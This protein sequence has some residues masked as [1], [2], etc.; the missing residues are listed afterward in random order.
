[1]ANKN[2]GRQFPFQF[3]CANDFPFSVSH[4]HLLVYT[5]PHKDNAR[6]QSHPVDQRSLTGGPQWAI[7][8]GPYGTA[9]GSTPGLIVRTESYYLKPDGTL[10]F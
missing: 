3:V 1:M 5:G 9:S 4:F 7:R 8:P 6:D 10:L 2:T